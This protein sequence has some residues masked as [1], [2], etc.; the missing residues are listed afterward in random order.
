MKCSALLAVAIAAAVGYEDK[1]VIN[2]LVG[3]VEWQVDPSP[4]LT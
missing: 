1:W 4:T 3:G 2:Q